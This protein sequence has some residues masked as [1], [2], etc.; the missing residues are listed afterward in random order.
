VVEEAQGVA[1]VGPGSVGLGLAA[2][3]SLAGHRVTLCGRPDGTPVESIALDRSGVRSRAA[4]AWAGAPPVETI[5]RPADLVVLSTKLHQVDAEAWLRALVG[6]GS[7][8]LVAQN[9]IGHRERW[10]ALLPPARIVPALVTFNATRTDRSSVDVRSAGADLTVPDDRAGRSVADLLRSSGLVVDTTEDF[11]TAAWRK[12]LVNAVANPVTAVTMRRLDVF[13]EHLVDDLAHRMLAE[14]AQVARADGAD[15]PATAAQEAFDWI[16]GRP[17]GA[18]S[19][20]LDD[21]LAGRALEHDGLLG[22]VVR[23]GERYGIDQPA[24]RTLLALLTA[25]PPSPPPEAPAAALSRS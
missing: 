4:V 1:V 18:G 7:V 19:S 25:L 2:L 24:C 12:L 15:L 11:H 3:L 5:E 23:R 9:G 14:V 6:P 16:L 21:R 13:R 20:M 10:S 17:D 22:E 8:L